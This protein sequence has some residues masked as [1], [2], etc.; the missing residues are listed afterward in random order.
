[1]IGSVQFKPASDQSLL[2]YFA[3]KIT[4]KAHQ[5]VRKLLHLLE[6]EPIAGVR[7]LH[8][9]YCSLLVDFDALQLG[10]AELAGILRDYLRRAETLDWR[11]PRELEIPTC[12]GGEFGPDLDVLA[13][14]HRMTPAEVV[15]LH[16]SVRY[17]VYFLGFVPGF[18]YLGGLPEQLA[19]PRLPNPRRST[20]AGSVGIAGKQ[21]GVYPFATPGGW[22]V[23]GRTPL[24]MF[25][26]SREGMSLL[27]V[28]D[29][30]RF[31]PISVDRFRAIESR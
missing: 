3:A 25:D 15:K 28:G 23:I 20:P 7:N 19:T 10:H 5:R 2:V 11:E 31:L 14:L 9:A 27:A 4:L 30:V 1:M 26:L 29:H 16:S 21:T 18:A 13:R 12:Y 6:A 8:P 22:R 24:T 17:V